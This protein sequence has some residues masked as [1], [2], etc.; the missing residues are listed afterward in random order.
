MITYKAAYWFDDNDGWV[1]AQVL[2]FPGAI[3]QG[4]GLNDARKMLQSALVDMAESLILDG[5][6][7]PKPD[8]T[9]T[10]DAAE[11]VEPIHL[12]LTG[13]SHV[14]ILPVEAA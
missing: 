1:C 2:D 9:A 12:L 7:L 8:P 6:P 10:S 4:Q 5:D 3:S 14:R 11:I 13:A